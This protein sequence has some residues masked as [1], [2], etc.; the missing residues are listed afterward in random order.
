MN[1]EIKALKQEKTLVEPNEIASLI[2]ISAVALL[3]PFS[4][5]HPQLLVGIIVNTCLV[6]AAL[7]SKNRA[8]AL[9]IALLPSVGVIARGLVFGP[10]TP[11]LAFMVP[12]IWAGNLILM[13]GMKKIKNKWLALP[14]SAILKSAFLY[15]I[16]LL[17]IRAGVLPQIFAVSMGAIQFYTALAGGIIA[18]TILGVRS[19]I[20]KKS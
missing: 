4:L 16:A 10:F 18:L 3:V 17:F 9:P 13:F 12:F 11:L 20:Q 6:L 19:K 15:S 2:L 8:I 1:I 5:G 14:I 7:S